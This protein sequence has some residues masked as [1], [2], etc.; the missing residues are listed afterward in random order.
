MYRCVKRSCRHIKGS[1]SLC[2]STVD[3]WNTDI[4]CILLVWT[5]TILLHKEI[6]CPNS[7]TRQRS[8]IKEVWNFFKLAELTLKRLRKHSWPPDQSSTDITS[9][10]FSYSSA[11]TIFCFFDKLQLK[12]SKVHFILSALHP[13]KPTMKD[14]GFFHNCNDKSSYEQPTN[15]KKSHR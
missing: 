5:Y 1:C 3:Y 6:G 7:K 12:S 2:H 15:H 4:A 14:G 9:F 10:L 8:V 13:L 11:A